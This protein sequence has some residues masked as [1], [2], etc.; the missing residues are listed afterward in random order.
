MRFNQEYTSQDD[1]NKFR[2]D[3]LLNKYLNT[4]STYE[5][6]WLVDKDTNTWLL[7]IKRLNNSESLWILH[8]KDI[9]IEIELFKTKKG[10]YD[11]ISISPNSLN[12]CVETTD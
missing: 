6:N 4:T 9:N 1:I 5:H 10:D 7:P 11:L 8:Y 2:L 12:N 3:E